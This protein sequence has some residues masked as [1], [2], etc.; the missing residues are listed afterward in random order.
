MDRIEEQILSYP[1]LSADDQREVE[2]YVESNPEWAPLLRDV[3]AIESLLSDVRVSDADTPAD[4]LV[5]TY[6]LV[7]ALHPDEVPPVLD[8]ALAGLRTRIEEDPALQERVEVVRRRLEE[9]EA[10][11]DPVA[12]FEELTGR[13]LEPS[14]EGASARA[15]DRSRSR[16]RGR[17]Q[18]GGGSTWIL[19]DRLLHLSRAARWAGAVAALLAGTYLTLFMASELSQSPVDR[20][21]TVD[22]SDE[23]VS[24]YSATDTRS[25]VPRRDTL[26]V[27]NLYLEALSVLREAHT[28]TLGLF[29]TYDEGKL[30]EAERLLTDVLERTEEGSFLALEAQF[31]LGKAY[32][33]QRRIDA[34]R[35]RFQIV[36]E[37]E[38][39][40]AG[41]A[42]E[43]LEALEEEMPPE[44]TDGAR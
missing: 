4:R 34:A 5:T 18:D 1:H 29:P 28:S 37:R 43:I 19:L 32:L 22:V 7:E 23:V 31:Y 40:Q 2:T 16:N 26:S 9:A 27:D 25:V 41:E 3:R 14:T 10:A 38:G 20:L 36:V 17:A 30:A 24:A 35:S 6:V 39:R 13:A 15:S 8:K 11:V 21:A 44:R 42:R 33:A 12:Q